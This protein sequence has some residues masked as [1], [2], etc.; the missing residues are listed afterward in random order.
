M[1][2]RFVLVVVGLLITGVGPSYGSGP[3]SGNMSIPVVDGFGGVWDATTGESHLFTMTLSQSPDGIVNGSYVGSNGSGTIVGRINSEGK[4][5][6]Q[7]SQQGSHG[8]G[9]FELGPDGRTF[10][11]TYSNSDD[12]TVVNGSLYGTRKE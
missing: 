4:L 5:V 8:S 1:K 12:P 10:S 9:I 2:H 11:G 6:Y 7:W 3:D